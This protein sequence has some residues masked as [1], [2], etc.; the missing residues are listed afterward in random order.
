MLRLAVVVLGT[1]TLV[2]FA[3][4]LVLGETIRRLRPIPVRTARRR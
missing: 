2:S 1:W 4:A 3:V